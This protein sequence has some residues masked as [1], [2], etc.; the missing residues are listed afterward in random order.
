M[1]KNRCGK[2]LCDKNPILPQ[3][4][5]E[6]LSQSDVLISIMANLTLSTWAVHQEVKVK[7]EGSNST[8]IQSDIVKQWQGDFDCKFKGMKGCGLGS[9]VCSRVT[10]GGE[11]VRNVSGWIPRPKAYKSS[12]ETNAQQFTFHHHLAS[13]YPS[14]HPTHTRT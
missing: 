14:H 13:P 7:K 10:G 3:D 9:L 11:R 1:Y 4:K 6:E 5:S 2:E 8:F 12:A